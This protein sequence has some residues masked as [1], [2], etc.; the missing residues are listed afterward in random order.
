M[1]V[2]KDFRQKAREAL[3]GK[4]AVAVGTGWVATL[5]GAY[6]AL[7]SSSGGGGSSS[8]STISDES[9]ADVAG[10][11]AAFDETTV[12]I[13]I[14]ALIL[15]ML[16][17]IML[18]V[19]FIIGGAVTLGYVRFN[20]NLID[21]NNPRFA[22]L[23][24]QFHHLGKGLV[25]Q[26]LRN[27]YIILWTLL[28]IIPGVVATYRYAMAPYLMHDFPEL[29]ASEAISESKRLMDGNKWRLFCLNFSF[30]GW[31]ILCAFTLGIGYLWL[32][33]YR[34]AAFAAFY[35]EIQYGKYSNTVADYTTYN[36]SEMHP[37]N[38][39]Y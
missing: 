12:I 32:A 3:S 22:D 7:G 37:E 2:A 18:L 17:L 25:L 1:L 15:V 13:G 36:F 31:D 8:S 35:K 21:G 19:H 30:I 16:V 5:L 24:S 10:S 34:E 11:S 9:Y 33:P 6:T 39:Q 14:L 29:S 28:F 23:F 27:I 38:T 20:L 4:W 26:F